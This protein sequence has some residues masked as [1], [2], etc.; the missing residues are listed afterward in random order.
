M[1]TARTIDPNRMSRA[2]EGR[3]HTVRSVSLQGGNHVA[4]RVHRQA[5]LAVT[6]GFHNHAR[7]NSLDQQ[8]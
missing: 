4:V 3:L 7:M 5:D 2:G 1:L 8:Q 6:Q